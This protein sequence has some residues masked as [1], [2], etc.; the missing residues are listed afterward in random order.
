MMIGRGKKEIARILPGN[1]KY[2][3]VFINVYVWNPFS[4]KK[5]NAVFLKEL[6][7]LTDCIL[8]KIPLLK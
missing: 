3:V 1:K 7:F 2:A 5:K 4:V 6:H 8:Y